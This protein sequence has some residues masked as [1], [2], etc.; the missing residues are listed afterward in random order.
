MSNIRTEFYG[1][2]VAKHGAKLA[3]TY[4]RCRARAALIHEILHI[5][6][7]SDEERVR[8]LTKEYFEFYARDLRIENARSIVSIILFKR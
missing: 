3:H 7:S 4:V 8:R 5:K 6:Y 2:L 1:K